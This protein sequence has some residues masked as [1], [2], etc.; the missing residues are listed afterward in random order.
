MFP[1]SDPHIIVSMAVPLSNEAAAQ[2]FL[3]NGNDAETGSSIV[4]TDLL[5][6]GTGPA[7][8]SLACFLASH[9]MLASQIFERS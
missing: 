9:G 6:V 3:S 4:E 1:L 5:I 2:D 8:A 7:G